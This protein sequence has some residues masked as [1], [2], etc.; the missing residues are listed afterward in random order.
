MPKRLPSAET[1]RASPFWQ[2]PDHGLSAEAAMISALTGSGKLR[3]RPLLDAPVRR[4]DDPLPLARLAEPRPELSRRNP[5]QRQQLGLDPGAGA[6]PDRKAGSKGALRIRRGGNADAG[7]DARPVPVR[8]A[9]HPTAPGS[10]LSLPAPLSGTG[11]APARPAPAP[12]P[13][14][15]P[16]RGVGCRRPWRAPAPRPVLRRIFS[17]MVAK[18]CASLP[19][20]YSTAAQITPPGIGD[21]VGHRRARRARAARARLRP[22]PGCWRPASD[23]PRLQLADVVLADHVGAR[24]RDPDVAVDADHRVALER[25]GACRSRSTLPPARLSVDERF[26][27]DARRD[28]AMRAASVGGGDQHRAPLGEEARRVMADGAEALHRDPRALQSQRPRLPPPPRPRRRGRSRWRRSRRA[29]CRRS[30]AAGRRRGRSRRAPRPC[31]ARRCPCRGRGCS[32]ADRRWR[33][34]GA[35][36]RAPC[37]VGRHRR[38]GEDHRLAAAVRQAG[39]GVLQRHRAGESEALLE[40][41]VR[42]HAHAADRGAAGHVVDDHDGLQA[43]RRAPRCGS[44]FSGPRSSA[45]RRASVIGGVLPGLSRPVRGRRCSG[46]Q[47]AGCLAAG[48]GAMVE[49]QRQRQDAADRGLPVTASTARA[50]PSGAEDRHLRRHDHQRGMLAAEHA[51]VGQRDGGAAQLLGREAAA[52]GRGLQRF[53]PLCQCLRLRRRSPPFS[54]G[55]KSPS[56]VSTAMPRS[57]P[58]FSTARARRRSRR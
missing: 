36:Q 15:R 50:M 32:R 47:E 2:A 46:G 54:T 28:R 39:G 31:S 42:R 56:G 23:Q 57:T 3:D 29:E 8:L 10:M 6:D 49:G 48:D 21:E 24:G 7:D 22:S 40:R 41:H 44:T 33:G 52:R 58:E 14:R 12:A 19:P 16:P 55:T 11:A 45:K 51:E 26:D 30:R 25:L 4:D 34:E 53:E 35:H 18:A 5:S 20:W 37:R 9:S 43:R 13:A 27:V 17:S 1:R 38:V